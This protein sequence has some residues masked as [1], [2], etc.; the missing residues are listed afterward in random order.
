M[1]EGVTRLA[2]LD[3]FVDKALWQRTSLNACCAPGKK[4]QIFFVE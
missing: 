3:A 4:V 2:S 1:Y